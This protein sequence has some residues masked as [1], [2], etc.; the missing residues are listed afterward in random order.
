MNQEVPATVAFY[1]THLGFELTLEAEWYVSLT[2][3]RW[4]LAILDAAHPSVPVTG[5]P[6]AGLLLN[7]EVDDVGA[8]YDRLVTHGRLEALVGSAPPLQP[9]PFS[10]DPSST[11]AAGQ[12]TFAGAHRGAAA[13]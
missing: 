6:A 5:R 10:P 3:D 13:P 4:E 2:R 9:G 7:L 11:V 12:R 8:E 1:R